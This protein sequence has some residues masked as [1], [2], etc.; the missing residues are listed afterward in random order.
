MRYRLFILFVLLLLYTCISTYYVF[1]VYDLIMTVYYTREIFQVPLLVHSQSMTWIKGTMYSPL[2]VEH[3]PYPYTVYIQMQVAQTERMIQ[4]GTM[5]MTLRTDNQTYGQL[6]TMRTENAIRWWL[7]QILFIWNV[8][9]SSITTDIYQL[10]P[11]FTCDD[12]VRKQTK[13]TYIHS[14]ARSSHHTNI[15]GTFRL[16]K[17][18]H[19]QWPDFISFTAVYVPVFLN[20]PYQYLRHARITHQLFW[21]VLYTLGIMMTIVLMLMYGIR[22]CRAARRE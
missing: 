5:E 10:I 8:F 22:S 6:V 4:T 11:T 15:V 12:V 3:C 1:V 13:H 7:W 17:Q 16:R 21:L 14:M 18:P 9:S 19:H 2:R 20:Q